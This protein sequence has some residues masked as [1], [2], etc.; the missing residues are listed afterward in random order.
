MKT[1][2]QLFQR[3]I[4][5]KIEEVIKVSAPEGGDTAEYEESVRLEIEEYVATESIRDHFRTVYKAVADAPS[6]PHEGI[7]IW[8]SG[9]F[10]SGKSSFAKILGYTLAGRTLGGK[11]ASEAFL[12]VAQD[13][14]IRDLLTLVNAKIPTTAVIFDVS[15]E[16]GVRTASERITEILYKALLRE[17]DYSEDF[18]LAHLEM[19]LEEDRLLEDFRERFHALH[20]Q[21]WEKRRKLGR[22]VNE[23]SVVLHE[24]QPKTFPAADSWARSLGAGRADITPTLLAEKAFDLMARRRKGAALVFVVDEVGQYVSRSVQKMLDLQA[25][26][27][28]FGVAGKNRVK[29]R[30]ANAPCW[31]VV[32]SQE[33]LNE[34]VDSLEGKKVELARLQERFPTTIDLKQSDISEVTGKRVL[35]KSPDGRKVLADLFAKNEGRLKS[36]CML[37]HTKREIALKKEEFVALYPY[38]PYQIDLCIDIV[39]GLRLKRGA[40]RH[41]GGSNRTIIKQAQQMLVHPRT[42]LAGQPVG[43]LVTLDRVYELLYLGNLLPSEVTRE[44][45]EV[46]RSL[47]NVPMATSVAKAIALL[48]AVSD[49][50]RTPHN[51]AV[52]LHPAVEADAVR[53]SVK[54]ALVALEGAQF[55]RESEDGYKLL[56][57]EE[58]SWDIERKGIEPRPA[59]RNRIL[60]EMLAEVFADPKVKNYRHKSNRLFKLAILHEGDEID[61]DGHVPLDI[62]FA[63]DSSETA[64]R[65]KDARHASSE[66]KNEIYWVV[67]LSEEAHRLLE[68][69]HRSREMV[70]R[71][72]REQSSGKISAD[73]SGCLAEEKIRRD[74]NQRDLRNRLSDL[75]QSGTGFFQGVQKDGSSLGKSLPDVMQQLLEDCVPALYPKLEMGSR[76]LKGDEPA[77][78]LTAANLEGL[79]PVFFDGDNGLSLV[80][81]QSGKF[82]PNSSAEICKEVLAYVSKEDS[83]GRKVTGKSLE[84][85]F[86]GIGYG[87]ERDVLRLVLAVLLRAGAI[88]VTHQG[89]KY[90]NHNDPACREPFIGNAAFKSASFSPR[91]ALGLK[92]LTDAT[93]NYERIT[94]TEVDI[95][96]EAIAQAFRRIAAEDREQL[97]PLVSRMRV[98]GL[99]GL[100]AMEEFLE[101]A[102]G[103]LEM[104]AD[105]C[106][107]TLAGEGAAYGDSRARL[108]RLRLATEGQN[109]EMLRSARRVL[110]TEWPAIETTASNLA[111]KAG[112]LRATL[113]SEDFDASLEKIRGAAAAIEGEHRRLYESAHIA[114]QGAVEIAIDTL[115]GTTDW[116]ALPRPDKETADAEERAIL[117]PLE[118]RSCGNLALPPG[119][120]VCASCRASLNELA[121]DL[122]AIPGRQATSMQL[123]AARL[124]PTERVER[125]RLATFLSGTFTGPGDVEVAIERLKAHLLKL[126]AEGARV[127]VE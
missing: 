71:G 47:A 8:V 98:L 115:R 62:F 96:E 29:A 76:P 60:R 55:V 81:K 56:T 87:W 112:E 67:T 45:D 93:R 32:T 69:V 88:E 73:R 7:G 39:A 26:V 24:M 36:F 14:R 50:P 41:I 28:A 30:K 72:E 113:D 126:L 77:V 27:Q 9:F 74:R 46:A 86:Q 99:P 42:N 95:E 84:A 13:T 1:I 17:L 16:R 64:E 111:G 11:S 102:Q 2:G 79:P 107:K 54:A 117:L 124:S 35:E 38:L 123:L 104:P 33:K 110:D 91:E 108:K 34:V 100:E 127:V 63:Q 52:V 61:P 57:V 15:M 114:R 94:G 40:Q 103:I 44:I 31:I 125:V 3:N 118:K 20:E 18:D 59:D 80:V 121:A 23:A 109:L 25:L 122:D 82:V 68:E 48:E 90:R 83:Y 89:R 12:A 49:L 119:A 116:A 37:E 22:A 101:V 92:M 43:G 65:A 75:V 85:H 97:L 21:P 6:D 70:V 58:K 78:F 5:R 51:L 10:G 120:A 53:E 106:V 105:D 66:R 4:D 19:S